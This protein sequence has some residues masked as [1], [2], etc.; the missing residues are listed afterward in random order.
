MLIVC[1]QAKRFVLHVAYWP[2]A[3]ELESGMPKERN[4]ISNRQKLRLANLDAF[5]TQSA[6]NL[7]G[8]VNWQNEIFHKIALFGSAR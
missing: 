7:I 4:H 8:A 2:L 6:L 3:R 5:V 1:A